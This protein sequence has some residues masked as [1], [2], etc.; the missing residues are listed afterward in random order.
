MPT[1][2]QN[3]ASSSFNEDLYN[4]L[5]GA[6]EPDLTTNM[7]PVLD[8]VYFGETLEEH[9]AR[10]QRY[11]KAVEAFRTRAA[12]FADDFKSA[13]WGIGEHAMNLA[14]DIQKKADESDLHQAETNLDNA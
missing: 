14:R 13:I 1:Q 9:N 8:E 5:M 6:I 4:I 7:I 2:T 12:Q 11:T 10:M 3:P